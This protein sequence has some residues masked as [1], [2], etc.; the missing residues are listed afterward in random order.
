MSV[1]LS[2]RGNS[3]RGMQEGL[4]LEPGGTF[5][6]MAILEGEAEDAQESG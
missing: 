1:S 2:F 5:F 3:D 6:V 4:A